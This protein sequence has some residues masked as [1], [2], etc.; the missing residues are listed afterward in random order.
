MIT[1]LR[2][3]FTGFLI[4]LQ[5]FTIIPVH[6]E[7]PMDT[8]HLKYTLH[9]MPLAG[10]VHGAIYSGVIFLLH[11][12]TGLSDLLLALTFWLLLIILTGGIHLDGLIDTGDAYF[13][14]KN[15]TGRLE[16]MQDPRVGA[17]GVL[18]VIV[19]LFIRFIIIFELISMINTGT[20]L[21]IILIP[22]LGKMYT[23][24]NLQLLSPARSEGL[25]VFFQK[26][27]SK[28]FR[29][30]NAAYIITLTGVAWYLDITLLPG[31]LLLITI[32]VSA[33]LLSAGKIKKHF[34]GITGD[35]LGAGYEGMEL[36]LWIT[37][38]LLHYFAMV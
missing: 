5:F 2:A 21:F 18:T 14:Y 25:A 38:L 20:Y 37:L 36:L 6:K 26:G 12:Y 24:A 32:M 10:L 8:V 30:F 3:F 7:L 34:G 31:I 23:A 29:V 11:T 17:F 15:T 35:I 16:A 19:F 9:A 1:Q 27:R 4:N 33:G 28:Y 13:S 22:F